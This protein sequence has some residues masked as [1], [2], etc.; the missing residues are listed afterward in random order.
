[1]PSAVFVSS[2]HCSIAHRMPL[3][4][5]HRRN[6]GLAGALLMSDAYVGLAPS[7]RLITS[8]TVRS[9][10]PALHSVTRVRANAYALG[11]WVP[12]E[13]VRRYHAADGRL[14]A[15]AV[16]VSGVCV[17]EATTRLTRTS[18]LEVEV[19]SVVGGRWSQ[20]RV[21]AGTDTNAVT[22]TQAS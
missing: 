3:R 14:S 21:S 20:Q 12:A 22:P 10:S 11:P 8:Q 6:G 15:N 5:T 2:Q 17:G 13:T 16:T 18:P 9:G 4:H 19:C 1:M 7:V